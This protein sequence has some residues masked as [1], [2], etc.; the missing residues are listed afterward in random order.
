ML[1]QSLEA[2]YISSL[3]SRAMSFYL[4]A[5]MTSLPLPLLSNTFPH[6]FLA[7]I[8]SFPLPSAPAASL[9]LYSCLSSTVYILPPFPLP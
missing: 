8:L 5:G 9:S 6:H 3:I 4:A 2:S 7:L 1:G